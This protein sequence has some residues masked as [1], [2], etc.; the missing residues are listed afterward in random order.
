MT[1]EII[2]EVT[3]PVRHVRIAID[4]S[5]EDARA[6]F[7]SILLQLDARIATWLRNGKVECAR[8]ALEHGPELSIFRR[9]RSGREPLIASPG[10]APGSGLTS[11]VPP[12]SYG[13]GAPSYG[14]EGSWLGA[15]HSCG[16][17][18]VDHK[19][20]ERPLRSGHIPNP[21]PFYGGG[22]RDVS[23]P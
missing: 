17:L 2:T 6:A 1:S 22:I 4:A 12:P 21:P 23:T 20:H 7:E 14:A 5:F 10:A 13:G 18:L 11:N 9:R 8:A 16:A 15:R 3:V 19:S